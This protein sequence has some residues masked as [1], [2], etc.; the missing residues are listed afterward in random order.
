MRTLQ[1]DVPDDV[2][3]KIEAAASERG[4]SVGELVR[5]SIEEKLSRES[6]VDVATSYVLAK[7][8]ELYRRLS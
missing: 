7:N 5:A 8:A 2:A 4:V 6:S 3:Q 1:I